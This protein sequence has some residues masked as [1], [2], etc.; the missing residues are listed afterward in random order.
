MGLLVDRLHFSTCVLISTLGTAAAVFGLW[1]LAAS[2]PTLYAFCVAYGLFAACW[3][4][5]WPGIMRDVV[6]ARQG[7]DAGM[8]FA[9]LAAGK[10]IG[11]IASGPLSE[12][13]LLRGAAAA[14]AS[15]SGSAVGYG[16]GYGAVIV[17]TGITAACGACS[18]AAKRVGWL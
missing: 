18:F 1:A 14:V 9:S 17:F 5:T 10:G 11:S 6:R 12:A 16:S 4:S 13:L 8:V 3:A 2:L 7:A 15:G